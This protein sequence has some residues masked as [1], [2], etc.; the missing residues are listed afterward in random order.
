MKNS[1]DKPNLQMHPLYSLEYWKIK[2]FFEDDPTI[3]VS[4][5]NNADKSCKITV[6]DLLK[7]IALD[8]LL[9]TKELNVHVELN[10][11]GVI[12]DTVD[13]LCKDNPKYDHM[14]S[15]VDRETGTVMLKALMFK[16]E[17][18]HYFS[19]DMFSPT[20]HTAVLPSQLA[21]DLFTESLN[22]QTLIEE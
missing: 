22:F 4:D 21:R 14:E 18:M 12:E 19:D 8:T 11:S 16:A 20:G 15:F 1:K 3:E 2:A 10:G 13:Y 7:K 17:S 5:I 9:V 6:K